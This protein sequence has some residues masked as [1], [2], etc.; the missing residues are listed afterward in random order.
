MARVTV[1]DSLE[2]IPNRFDLILTASKRA[3]DLSMTGEDPT[4]AWDNDKPTVVA[5]R[6]IAAGTVDES[7][8]FT[9]PKIDFDEVM[10]FD[11]DAQGNFHT[12]QTETIT[13]TDQFGSH[14]ATETQDTTLDENMLAAALAALDQKSSDNTNEQ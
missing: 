1:E 7:V 8:L 5:L 10:R 12:E 13:V 2:K 14:T 9:K 11:T 6:E 3:R 4:V